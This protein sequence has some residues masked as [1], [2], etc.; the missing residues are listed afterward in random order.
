[1]KECAN[2]CKDFDK[3]TRKNILMVFDIDISG[4]ERFYSFKY[5]SKR[6]RRDRIKTETRKALT[7]SYLMK[8]LRSVEN[9]RSAR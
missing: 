3:D 9:Y 1:M 8:S 7:R 2:R 5:Y 4:K 6:V